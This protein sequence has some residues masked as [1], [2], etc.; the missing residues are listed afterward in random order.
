MDPMRALRK[1]LFVAVVFF[2][3]V[4]A[5]AL[6]TAPDDAPSRPASTS[7]AVATYSHDQLQVDANM[8]QQM[9]TP[10]ANTGSQYHRTDGQLER[11]QSAGYIAALEQHQADVDRMLGRG[12]P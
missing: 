9:S 1:L 8:T 6:A 7:G 2:G 12:A 10:N 5:L 3:S 4:I 11:S